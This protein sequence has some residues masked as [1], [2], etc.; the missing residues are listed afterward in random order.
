MSEVTLNKKAYQQLIDEDI[1]AL[2]KHMPEFSLEKSHIIAVL[3]W[4]VEK[5]YPKSYWDRES[6]FKK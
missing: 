5:Q 4:S 6:D 1:Q 2:E 3:K